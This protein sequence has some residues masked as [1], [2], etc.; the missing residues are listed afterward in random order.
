MRK[1]IP[2]LK[3]RRS[4]SKERKGSFV[5]IR[6]LTNG[7]IIRPLQDVLDTVVFEKQFTCVIIIL[8]S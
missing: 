7:R 1:K 3:T 6:Y 2:L 5:M 4:M 8:L